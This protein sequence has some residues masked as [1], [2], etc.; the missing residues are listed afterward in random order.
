MAIGSLVVVDELFGFVLSVL[1]PE[2]SRA[3]GM[4]K[5]ALAGVLSAKL[6][7]VSVATLPMAAE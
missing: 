4:S 7:A 3:L 1:G 6:L 2:I 5:G